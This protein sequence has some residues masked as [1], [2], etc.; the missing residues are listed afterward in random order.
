MPQV[1]R[2]VSS[3]S[4]HPSSSSQ[5]AT[6]NS[7][8]GAR[9]HVLRRRHISHPVAAGAARWLVK[10]CVT[11]QQQ[12]LI[13]RF[14]SI[15]N[16]QSSFLGMRLRVLY[17]KDNPSPGRSP[18]RV[19]VVSRVETKVRLRSRKS[20]LHPCR[21]LRAFFH[22]MALSAILIAVTLCLSCNGTTAGS[23]QLL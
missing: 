15:N 18:H 6:H 13:R 10:G 2:L 22:S 14:R 20:R 7:L 4:T 16:T 9:L 5:G 12:I 17:T 11:L 21:L 1:D 8:E 3:L 19:K 23:S